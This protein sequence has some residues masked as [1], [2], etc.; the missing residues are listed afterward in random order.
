V[1]FGSDGRENGMP[2]PPLDRH[3]EPVSDDDTVV[4]RLRA[5]GCVFAED[6]A[7]LLRECARS[8]GE[9][10]ELVQQRTDGTPLE[11]LLG[12]VKFHG[13]RIGLRPGVFVPRQRTALLVDEA[14]TLAPDTTRTRDTVTVVDMCC[15]S[16][17]LAAAFAAEYSNTG[18]HDRMDLVA[19]DIDG[20]AADCA[21]A[22]LNRYGAQVYQGDLFDPLPGRLDGRIDLLLANTPYVPSTAIA[23]LPPEARLHEPVTALDGGPDGL[24]IFRRVAAEAHHWLRPGGHLLIEIGEEQADTAVAVLTEHGLDPRIASSAKLYATVAIGTRPENGELPKN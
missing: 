7:A 12:W 23:Q 8:D 18:E 19:C 16:G 10:D 20:V 2:E 17:A 1:R 14:L 4:S 11:Y 24:G 6:E 9:L 13:L 5:A 3:T 21:R 22:N 15:G